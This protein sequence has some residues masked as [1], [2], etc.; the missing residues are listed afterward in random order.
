MYQDPYEKS[1]SELKCQTHTSVK[2]H[3]KFDFCWGL[4]YF[5]FRENANY[6]TDQ[7]SLFVLATW[8]QVQFT[9]RNWVGS[10][11]L[12]ISILI[13]LP[14]GASPSILIYIFP[15]DGLFYL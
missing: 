14:T 15:D 2:G 10:Y 11:N 13:N 5:L 1:L 7:V 12:H 9:F 3:E 4:V 8:S 6:I